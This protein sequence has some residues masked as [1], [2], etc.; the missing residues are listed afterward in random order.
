MKSILKTIVLILLATPIF[1]QKVIKRNGVTIVVA[2][3]D[4]STK[5]LQC[6][7]DTVIPNESIKLSCKN[8]Y[9]KTFDLEHSTSTSYNRALYYINQNYYNPD[10]VIKGNIKDRSLTFRG[11]SE[12]HSERTTMFWYIANIKYN[13]NLDFL[14]K[15]CI[16]NIELQEIIFNDNSRITNHSFPYL[17]YNSNCIPKKMYEK[18]IQPLESWMNSFYK[19]LENQLN[20]KELTSDEAILRIK[21]L[22]ELLDLEIIT[23]ENFE[24]EKSELLKFIKK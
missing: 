16:F 12:F 13:I 6:S 3:K 17:I 21:E 24:S 2:E 20:K 8:L 15:T 7:T 18:L 1:S 9:T 22:K 10:Y 5:K 4:T 19:N 11:N 14:E 23:K